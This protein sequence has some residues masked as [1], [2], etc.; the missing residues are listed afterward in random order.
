MLN[1]GMMENAELVLIFADD[2]VEMMGIASL[3]PS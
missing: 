3:H 1:S 2:T